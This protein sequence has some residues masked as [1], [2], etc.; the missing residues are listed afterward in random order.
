MKIKEM[1]TPKLATQNE[2]TDF[3]RANMPL[4]FYGERQGHTLS[5]S[6]N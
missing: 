6:V 1:E 3:F 4:D 2:G 5:E